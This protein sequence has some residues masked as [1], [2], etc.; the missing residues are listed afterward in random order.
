MLSSL[1]PATVDEGHWSARVFRSHSFFRQKLLSHRSVGECLQLVVLKENAQEALTLVQQCFNIRYVKHGYVASSK[2][3]SSDN[4][5]NSELSDPITQEQARAQCTS[6]AF[7]SD[8][9]IAV[10]DRDTATRVQSTVPL[11]QR[12]GH[13]VLCE[14]MS[15][16]C[17]TMRSVCCRRK[18]CE[19]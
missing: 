13:G 9:D 17:Y 8:E 16:S 19:R 4:H 10:V 6:V 14:G 18:D 5:S 11:E 12:T 1:N 7:I 2:D 3:N 15:Y